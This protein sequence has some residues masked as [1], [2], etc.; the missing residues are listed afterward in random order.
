LRLRLVSSALL[1]ISFLVGDASAAR[2]RGRVRYVTAK[3]AYLDVGTLSGLRVGDS[4]KLSRNGRSAGAC[5]IEQIS[6]HAAMCT[7]DDVRL[8]DTFPLGRAPATQETGP[9]PKTLPP[10]APSSTIARAQ[11]MLADTPVD[12]V[13]FKG[14]GL[15]GSRGAPVATAELSYN[16]WAATGGD[17]FQQERIDLAVR[18]VDLRFAGFR[19]WAQITA[20]AWSAQPPAVRFRPGDT[21]QLYVWETEASSRELGRP[22]VV[23]VGRIWPWHTPGLSVVDGAQI[24]YRSRDGDLEVGVVGGTIPDA[25]TLIPSLDRWT[26]G[27]YYAYTFAGKKR[28]ILRLLRTEARVGVRSATG[29]GLQVETEGLIEAW[30][31]KV[32]D[33]GAQARGT[34]GAGD[35]STPNLESFRAHAALHPIDTLRVSADI[36]YLGKLV[37]DYDGFTSGALAPGAWTHGTLDGSWEPLRW[38]HVSLVSGASRESPD[39][40]DPGGTR[41][42]VGP[43]VAFPSLLKIGTF[44]IGYREEFGWLAGR[45][46]FLGFLSA[47]HDRIRLIARVSY[48]EDHFETATSS[49][50][51]REIGIYANGDVR[52]TRWLSA[53]VSAMARVDLTYVNATGDGTVPTAAG[54]TLHAG[55]VGS[56]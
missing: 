13:E 45:T 20:Y 24:G 42:F 30:V 8:G 25:M 43:E 33:V 44:S 38:L 41:Y 54:V 14:G 23:S 22:F 34:I 31:T 15:G 5:K 40:T 7:S 32:L 26:A 35:W 10:P 3:H 50:P 29:P 46:A 4:V 37:Y 47:P 36:R 1:T 52:I 51:M 17:T 18:G 11:V 48:F 6:E 19:A 21:A 16:L 27:A 28:S 39:A 9:A 53:R 55:L 56:L 2:D 49:E 12:K